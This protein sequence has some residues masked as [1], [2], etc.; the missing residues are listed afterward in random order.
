MNIILI[1]TLWYL[2]NASLVPLPL[3][4]C[5]TVFGALGFIFGCFNLGI[6]IGSISSKE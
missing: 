5:G 3:A 4:I 6:K 2:Y 1:I